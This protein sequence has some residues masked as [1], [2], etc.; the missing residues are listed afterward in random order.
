MKPLL[1]HRARAFG[2]ILLLLTLL[3]SQACYHYRIMAPNFDPAT[4]YQSKTIHNLCWGLVQPQDIRPM[5][6]E[7]SNALDE[8]R[9]STNL[10]YAF[11]TVVTLGIW[12]PVK[13][14]WKC[15]K[16]CTRT[17]NF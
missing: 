5:N 3:C 10:G 14:E 15:S 8:V 9:Y 7:K 2:A 16:P 12:C 6:C 13:V 17:G 4:E 1:S 11:L